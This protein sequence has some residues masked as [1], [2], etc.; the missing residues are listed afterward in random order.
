MDMTQIPNDLMCDAFAG[1]E[2]ANTKGASTTINFGTK[3]WIPWASASSPR[4]TDAVSWIPQIM[5]VFSQA[6]DVDSAS[7][8]FSDLFA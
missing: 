6:V 3:G 1:K 4:H 7:V 5:G 2:F 8:M